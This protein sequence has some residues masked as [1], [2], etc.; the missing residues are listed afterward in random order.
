MVAVKKGQE[1]SGSQIVCFLKLTQVIKGIAGMLQLEGT[2]PSALLQPYPTR[3]TFPFIVTHHVST[4]VLPV[5]FSQGLPRRQLYREAIREA[6]FSRPS[7]ISLSVHNKIQQHAATG[8]ILL[9]VSFVLW[10]MGTLQRLSLYPQLCD[11]RV[12]CHL[13]VTLSSPP[14]LTGSQSLLYKDGPMLK[15]KV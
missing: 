2:T 1:A 12:F 11:K 9:I 6:G 4:P 13:A 5:P 3:W 14:L 15:V 8:T 7:L 10:K